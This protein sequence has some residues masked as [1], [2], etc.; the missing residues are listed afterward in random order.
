MEN[1]QQLIQEQLQIQIAIQRVHTHIV[2]IQ[3]LVNV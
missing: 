3:Q 1:V 2:G